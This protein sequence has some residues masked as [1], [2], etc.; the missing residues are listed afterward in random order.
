MKPGPKPIKRQLLLTAMPDCSKELAARTGVN[1]K[2]TREQVKDLHRQNL[3]RIVAW[4][5]RIG[6]SG[7][8]SPIW[9]RG[10]G[11]D[12]PKPPSLSNAQACRHYKAK[13]Y[14][15]QL[16]EAAAR[17]RTAAALAAAKCFEE[18]R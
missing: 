18:S 17:Q 16:A 12:C 4:K 10:A 3:I 6:T 8:L 11:P 2:Y 14:A 5:R 7:S 9:A 1:Y 13:R 15:K